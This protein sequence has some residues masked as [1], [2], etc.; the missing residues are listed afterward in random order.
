[1]IA[2][3]FL[4]QIVVVEAHYA[5]FL[6]F[7]TAFELVCPCTR[8]A[9]LTLPTVCRYV[10]EA[11]AAMAPLVRD[12]NF[13][14]ALLDPHADRPPLEEVVLQ[15]LREF[16]QY[17]HSIVWCLHWFKHSDYVLRVYR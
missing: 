6:S 9:R 4:V 1:M 16:D 14:R 8:R 10:I 2:K 11:L 3:V 15:R 13:D 7:G 12:V 5:A 17:V